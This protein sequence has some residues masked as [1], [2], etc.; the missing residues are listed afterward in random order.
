MLGW[1]ERLGLIGRNVARLAEAPHRPQSQVRA[2][3]ES[4]VGAFLSA[5]IGSRWE[6][7]FVLAMATMMRRGELVALGCDAIDSEVAR[8]I[9]RRAFGE[10]RKGGWFLK[11]TKT[12]RERVVPLSAR[13]LDALRRVRARTAAEKLAAGPAY[14]DHGFVFCDELGAPYHPNAATKAFKAAALRARISGVSLHSLRH[15]G[16]TLSLGTAS[17]SDGCDP[18]RARQP[19]DDPRPLRPCDQRTRR[20]GNRR[21]RRRA[22]PRAE[23]ACGQREPGRVSGEAKRCGPTNGLRRGQPGPR[24]ERPMRRKP[25]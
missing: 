22:R 4:E 6:P 7:F 3:T 16:I 10:D 20:Q 24:A 8:L 17:T 13:A 15:T 11:S 18:G 12:A 5:I 23:A 19:G 14:R 1:A 21:P 9:V 2:M 25:L